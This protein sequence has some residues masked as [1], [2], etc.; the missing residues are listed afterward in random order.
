[1][2]PGTTTEAPP[3]A[4]ADVERAFER[5]LVAM[6][7]AFQ[8]I[9]RPDATLFGYEAL[10][11]PNDPQLPDPGALIEAAER[12]N[13][14]PRLGRA[15]RGLVAAAFAKAE[16]AHGLFFVNLHALDLV[17]P[18]LPSPY[19]PLAEYARRI[20]LEVTERAS[21]QGLAEV[22]DRVVDLRQMGYR[23]AIDDLGAGHAR[24][25]EF[26]PSDTDFVKLDLSVVRDCD[27]SRMK[28][29]FIASIIALCKENGIQVIGECVETEAEG[30]CLVGLGC[31]LLQG[32]YFARPGP[33]FP[34]PAPRPLI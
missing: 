4:L 3:L 10:L 19:S 28:Q 17:D 18:A 33:P 15:V 12:L 1:M 34:A 29:A 31:D 26:R 25:K 21:L 5:A 13:R 23:I 22:R 32:Y 30:R 6:H 2:D 20:V 24:M 7:M 9:V 16:E 27:G 14:L 11:R 8:P